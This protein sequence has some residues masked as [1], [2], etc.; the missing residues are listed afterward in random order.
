MYCLKRVDNYVSMVYDK[1]M[2]LW[3]L[4][5]VGKSENFETKCLTVLQHLVVR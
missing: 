2:T 5:F 3:L 4:L 1:T